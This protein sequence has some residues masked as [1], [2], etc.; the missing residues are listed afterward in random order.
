MAAA[1]QA[2]REQRLRQLVKCA[3]CFDTCKDPRILPCLHSFCF[4]CVKEYGRDAHEGDGL[5][6]PLC[7][8]EFQVPKGGLD[9][10]KKHF[11]LQELIDIS[12]M[13]SEQGPKLCQMCVDEDDSST[14]ATTYCLQCGQNMC[15]QCC[16]YH[17]K[18]KIS[19]N[20]ETRLLETSLDQT[21]HDVGLKPKFSYCEKHPDEVLRYFCKDCDRV[22]CVTCFAVDGHQSHNCSGVEGVAESHVAV[23]KDD[24]SKVSDKLG[25][26]LRVKEGCSA[27]RRMLLESVSESQ[28][29]ICA[30]SEDLKSIIN[31]QTKSALQSVASLQ[32]QIEKQIDAAEFEIDRCFAICDSFMNYANTLIDRGNAWDIVNNHKEV[33]TRAED[34]EK[35]SPSRFTNEILGSRVTFVPSD[36]NKNDL[37]LIGIVQKETE[38]TS[39][40]LGMYRERPA[41]PV[42][43]R[44]LQRRANTFSVHDRKFAVLQ[45][46]I[47]RSNQPRGLFYKANQNISLAGYPDCEAIEITYIIQGIKTTAYL[48]DNTEGREICDLL[49]KAFHA[50][51]LF[52]VRRSDETGKDNV[53]IFDD[54]SLKTQPTGPLVYY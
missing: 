21:S 51:L 19:K 28:R 11:F 1:K 27:S 30:F 3:I 22:I 24:I 54:I 9:E 8:A 34:L 12:R 18:M 4:P 33:H 45:R 46:T 23:I 43:A 42:A 26:C 41:V 13:S 17:R 25:E 39:D 35:L 7:K 48:P 44:C 50:G 47:L 15:N 20:H 40:S 53:V 37:N 36:T 31:A 14:P 52:T 49:E 32:T 2:S 29:A 6:C 38:K 10:L 16:A 5:V